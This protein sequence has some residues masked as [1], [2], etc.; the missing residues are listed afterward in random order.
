MHSS[1]VRKPDL[2]QIRVSRV[3]KASCVSAHTQTTLRGFAALP[4]SR[5]RIQTVIAL[6]LTPATATSTPA[7]PAVSLGRRQVFSR[8]RQA[9]RHAQSR[10][11]S[12][13]SRGGGTEY[14][15][16]VHR[17]EHPSTPLVPVRTCC[18]GWK[19]AA[20]S[21]SP[22]P[23]PL[24]PPCPVLCLCDLTAHAPQ[25]AGDSRRGGATA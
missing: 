8:R 4:A 9:C 6:S 14:G 20:R 18:R 15:A 5:L 19:G 22:P 23:A 16:R 10:R 12:H 3:L 17:V 2:C 11:N 7:D 13:W 25:T 1:N 24:A 21:L